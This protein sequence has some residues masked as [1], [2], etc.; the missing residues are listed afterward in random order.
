LAQQQLTETKGSEFL[1]KYGGHSRKVV[2]EGSGTRKRDQI[3]I[4]I[5]PGNERNS[6]VCKRKRYVK[7]VP[8][9]NRFFGKIL[10]PTCSNGVRF[11]CP[12]G[13]QLR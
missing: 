2:S 8:E 4:K 7:M 13:W 9:K 1:R 10:L 3:L 6:L 12:A 5:D 11:I